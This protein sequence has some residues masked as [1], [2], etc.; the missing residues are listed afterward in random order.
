[1]R[2][3]AILTLSLIVSLLGCSHDST[4]TREERV[5]IEPYP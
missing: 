1:M 3:L 2:I 5:Q 4:T